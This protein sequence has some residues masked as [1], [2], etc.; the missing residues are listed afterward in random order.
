[1]VCVAQ[2]NT[3]SV[4]DDEFLFPFPFAWL[5]DEATRGLLSADSA[6]KPEIHHRDSEQ[7]R[8]EEKEE[9]ELK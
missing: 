4:A 6:Q 2:R 7:R 8:E 5:L 1:M 9:K 3:A